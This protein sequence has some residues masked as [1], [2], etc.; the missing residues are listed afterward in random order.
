MNEELAKMTMAEQLKY[1]RA[2][3]DHNAKLKEEEKAKEA[4]KPPPVA[5]SKEESKSVMPLDDILQSIKEEEGD[6]DQPAAFLS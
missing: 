3:M 6:E 4:S 2:K 5:P 1:N